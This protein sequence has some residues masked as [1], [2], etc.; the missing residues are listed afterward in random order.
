MTAAAL[1]HATS[2]PTNS[3]GRGG[4]GFTLAEV[5][6]AMAVTSFIGIVVATSMS[7][8]FN[9]KSMVETEADTYRELRSG[10]SRLVREVSMAFLSNNYDTGRFR[11]NQ[12]RPTFFSGSEK[13]LSFTMLGHQ[14]LTRDAKES[15]Q[16]VVFFKVDR[17]PDDRK[18]SSLLRCEIPVISEDEKECKAWET[19]V[20]D[21]SQVRF[22]Y[23]DNV[24]DDWVRDWDTKEN[25]YT[26]KLPDRVKVEL[27][28]KDENGREQKYVTQA[29]INMVTALGL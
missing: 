22:S 12:D 17:D 9:A 29:R 25:E 6:L 1:R 20:S 3:L 14:R 5:L 28:G 11:D 15:D 19:L 21:I 24:K 23:W 27:T 2:A 7:V 13:E 18:L 26:N 4:R 10:T 8:A 16:S